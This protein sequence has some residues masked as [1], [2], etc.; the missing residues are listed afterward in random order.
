VNQGLNDQGV[1][2]STVLLSIEPTGFDSSVTSFASNAG[3]GSAAL[4]LVEEGGERVQIRNGFSY[5]SREPASKTPGQVSTGSRRRF[6]ILDGQPGP[7]QWEVLYIS[8]NFSTSQAGMVR[9]LIDSVSLSTGGA[10]QVEVTTAVSPL[11]GGIVSGG[12]TVDQDSEVTL[13]ATPNA[14]F[15]FDG[16]IGGNVQDPSNPETTLVSNEDVSVTATFVRQWELT[17]GLM[18]GGTITGAGVFDD[19]SVLPIVA[20][21]SEG[22][23][24]DSW[25]GTG[26][27]DPSNPMTNVSLGADQTVNASFIKVWDLGANATEG[28][29]VE[30]SGSYEEGAVVTI[31]ATLSEGFR[32][33]SWSGEGVGDMTA[34]TT[35]VTVTSNATVTANFVAVS[36]LTV[37]ASTGGTVVGDGE[38]DVGSVV[39]IMATPEEGYRFIGWDGEGVADVNALVAEVLISANGTVTAN[40][41]KVWGLAVS[42]EEGG[43]A[44]GIG[45]YDEGTV[46]AIS[47]SPEEGYRFGS[48][49]GEGVVDPNA[50]ITEII[51]V[52][53]SSVSARFVKVWS[54]TVTAGEGGAVEG[55][56]TYD[57]GTLVNIVA[58]PAEGYRFGSWTGEGVV[59]PSQAATEISV[60]AVNTASASFVK[61]WNLKL[62]ASE[63]GTAVGSGTFDAGEEISVSAVAGEGFQFVRWEGADSLAAPTSLETTVTLSADTTVTAVFVAIEDKPEDPQITPRI[64][65]FNLEG[66]DFTLRWTSV[67]GTAYTVESTDDLASLDWNPLLSV[68]AD[69]E[70]AEAVFGVDSGTYFRVRVAEED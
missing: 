70:E 25:S 28:G 61:V 64:T 35:E 50:A 3:F 33:A 2:I 54:L 55:G 39:S 49:I 40:F 56:G 34:T 24:F 62:S 21:P 32:F 67:M 16:W 57:D 29:T 12:D 66:T 30:G 59:D 26:V 36:T 22:Y 41:M 68:T 60:D 65:A 6:V 19:G 42:A 37:S 5:Y 1:P 10:T 14:G 48:W 69:G 58:M 53:E 17:F 38:F 11:D 43:T 27:I 46:V 31:Q 47:A 52:A 23:R 13:S 44:T 4:D 9:G 8:S 15:R 20:T 51:V 7:N 18:L 63:G 45:T